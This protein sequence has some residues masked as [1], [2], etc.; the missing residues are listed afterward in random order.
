M[1]PCVYVQ[2]VYSTHGDSEQY[3]CEFTY[4]SRFG[5][6]SI[7]FLNRILVEP[8]F[9]FKYQGLT[10]GGLLHTTLTKLTCKLLYECSHK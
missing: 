3:K 9:D 8:R 2:Y 5:K 1:R 4:N 7:A 10:N 6:K